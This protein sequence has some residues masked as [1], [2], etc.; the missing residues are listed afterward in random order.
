MRWPWQL[1]GRARG[2]IR[3]VLAATIPKGERSSGLFDRER[4]DRQSLVIGRW[5]GSFSPLI[6]R[7]NAYEGEADRVRRER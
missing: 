4:R 3:A 5:D 2:H 1:Q 6:Q 7:I